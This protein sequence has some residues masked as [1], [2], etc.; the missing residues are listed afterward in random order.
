[1]Q[2]E[3]RYD[4]FRTTAALLGCPSQASWPPGRTPCDRA[5]RVSVSFGDTPR[6]FAG[7]VMSVGT[8]VVSSLGRSAVHFR[9]GQGNA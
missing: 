3:V 9:P 6:L 2:G 4:P 7:S 8:E 5:S 1:V